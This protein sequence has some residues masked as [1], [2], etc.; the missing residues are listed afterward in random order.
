[1]SSCRHPSTSHFYTYL[2]LR[3]DGTPY[4]VGKGRRD[5]AYD[6]SGHRVKLPKDRRFIIIQE[7]ESEPAALLAEKF[8]IAAYGHKDLGTGCLRN[9]TD[10]GDGAA[11]AIRSEETRRR[12]GQAKLGNTHG[13]G[14]KV[15]AKV[16]EVL[17][18]RNKSLKQR[19]AAARRGRLLGFSVRGAGGH[20][21]GHQ[22]SAETRRKISQANTKTHCRRGHLRCPEN[23]TTDRGCRECA[24]ERASA[25]YYAHRAKENQCQLQQQLQLHP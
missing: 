24:R 17:L 13:L 20:K 7:Y 10:G 14:H 8:L 21:L 16:I 3:Y 25:Y 19:Q 2:Y 18:I 22:V 15:S 12:M 5:R 23:L 6:H 4:Y 9:R 11:G 1:M